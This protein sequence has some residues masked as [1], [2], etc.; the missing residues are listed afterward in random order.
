MKG[1]SVVESLVD[2]SLRSRTQCSLRRLTD[3]KIDECRQ[4]EEDTEYDGSTEEGLL[5]SAAGVET[6]R[7][8]VRTEGTPEGCAGA[9]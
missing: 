6:G 4:G 5:Q 1:F 7:E 3:N 8:V 2:L 9:L